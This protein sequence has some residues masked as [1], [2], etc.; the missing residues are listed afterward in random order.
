[1][2]EDE[3]QRQECSLLFSV[4]GNPNNF[5]PITTHLIPTYLGENNTIFV[6]ASTLRGNELPTLHV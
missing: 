1:M 2:E 3:I 6:T 4:L 5:A